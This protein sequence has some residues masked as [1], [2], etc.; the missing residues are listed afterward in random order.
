MLCNIYGLCPQNMTAKI[1][2]IRKQEYNFLLPFDLPHA[3]SVV[4]SFQESCILGFSYVK[5]LFEIQGFKTCNVCIKLIQASGSCDKCGCIFLY[6]G[7]NV[8]IVSIN[9]VSLFFCGVDERPWIYYIRPDFG[10]DSCMKISSRVA[11]EFIFSMLT[12]NEFR[13]VIS[14]RALMSDR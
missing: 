3:L 6:I 10:I 11:I 4:E 12:C 13:S 9:D 1:K 2:K 8:N 14:F 7:V 5:N